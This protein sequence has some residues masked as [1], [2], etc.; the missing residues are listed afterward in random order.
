MPNET[1]PASHDRSAPSY[2]GEDR[3]NHDQRGWH[4]DKKVP[5]AFIFA[6]LVQTVMVVIAFQDVK[7]DVAL[8]KADIVQ[9]Q[10]ADLRLA[11]DNKDNLNLIRRQYEILAMKLDRLIERSTK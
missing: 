6:L 4:L 2:S 9:L 11:G 1:K 8:S 7:R 5:I 3:R 10:A